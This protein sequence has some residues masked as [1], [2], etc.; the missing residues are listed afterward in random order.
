MSSFGFGGASVGGPPPPPLCQPA[1]K[2]AAASYASFAAPPMP[3]AAMGGGGDDGF[4]KEGGS[5]AF[6]PQA[7]AMFSGGGGVQAERSAKSSA[8]RNEAEQSMDLCKAMDIDDEVSYQEQVSP[9]PPPS[10]PAD[11]RCAAHPP[12][13]WDP[14]VELSCATC[15]LGPAEPCVFRFGGLGFRCITKP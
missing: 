2:G 7:D 3:C 1:P 14:K 6:E 15:G 11:D 9:P 10:P 5:P 4:A 12:T 13:R 8:R